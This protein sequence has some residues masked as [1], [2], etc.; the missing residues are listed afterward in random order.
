MRPPV[1]AP[2]YHRDAR[3]RGDGYG[4]AASPNENGGRLFFFRAGGSG[5]EPKVPQQDMQGADGYRQAYD[6]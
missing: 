1:T 6:L 2:P 3:Q 4:P 5:H